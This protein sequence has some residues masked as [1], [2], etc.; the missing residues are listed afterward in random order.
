MRPRLAVALLVAAGV[1]VGCR[2]TTG[3]PYF[4][5]FPEAEHVEIGFGLI[6]RTATVMQITDTVL[7]YLE[8][9]SIPF[10]KVRRFD[11]YLES[12]WLDA[13]TLRPVG[14]RPLGSNTVRVR[15]WIN[16]TMPGYAQVEAETSY[17][18][19]ADPSRPSRELEAPVDLIHPVNRRVGEVLKRLSARYGAPTDSVATPPPGTPSPGAQPPARPDTAARDTTARPA[20]AP[21]SAGSEATRRLAPL[22]LHPHV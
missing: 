2:A 16:P 22:T 14:R 12:A 7:A 4:D 6:D 18:T 1:A 21:D 19:M 17:N 5:P 15:V 11:G 9:D 10:A 20:P 8:A 3:R 13:E